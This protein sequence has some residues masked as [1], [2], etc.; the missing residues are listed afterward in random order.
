MYVSGGGKRLHSGVRNHITAYALGRLHHSRDLPLCDHREIQ[1]T[2]K[3]SP[4][5]V[6]HVL[7]ACRGFHTEFDDFRALERDGVMVLTRWKAT[8][9]VDT[10]SL[11]PALSQII[12]T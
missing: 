8:L 7:N 4:S 9:Y 11:R 2:T 6:A 10:S 1:R 12:N 5:C 3:S